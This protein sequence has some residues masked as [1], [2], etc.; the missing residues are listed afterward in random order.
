MHYAIG[1]NKLAARTEATSAPGRGPRSKARPPRATEITN[2][3]MAPVLPTASYPWPPPCWK[4]WFSRTSLGKFLHAR[5]LSPK[6]ARN[7]ANPITHHFPRS[8]GWKRIFFVNSSAASKGAKNLNPPSRFLHPRIPTPLSR[9]SQ[10]FPT[11]PSC[12][13]RANWR[14][15]NCRHAYLRRRISGPLISV[16]LP[17]FPRTA[18]KAQP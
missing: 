4:S 2:P 14:R 5:R 3:A 8:N 9:I 18:R 16:R 17:S 10:A 1:E 6:L 13:I 15:L 7:A 11:A 12:I